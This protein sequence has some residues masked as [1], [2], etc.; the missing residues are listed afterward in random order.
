MTT[1]PKWLRRLV[2]NQ[3]RPGDTVDAVRQAQ[4]WRRWLTA[5]AYRSK[6]REI[7]RLSALPRY[8]PATTTLLGPEMELADAAS[9]LGMYRE[10]FVQESYAFPADTPRPFIIDGGA[11][12]GVSLL[13]FK[14]RY[15]GCEVVAFEPDPVIFQLLQRNVQRMGHDG[16]ELHEKALWS[17]ATTLPFLREGSDGGRV[18]L[19]ADDR[20]RRFNEHC[21]KA[22]TP[23]PAIQ[24]VRLRDYLNRRVD[25]LKLDLEGAEDQVLLDCADALDR[26]ERVF[27]EY[28]SLVSE[29]QRLH[30]VLRVLV[31]AGFR[32]QVHQVTPTS[33]RPFM[34]TYIRWG[35]DLQLNIFASRSFHESRD[36]VMVSSRY[37][38]QE[39]VPVAA[40]GPAA[41]G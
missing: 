21:F 35:M 29:P 41:R 15:P 5:R 14:T 12:V 16:V 18:A 3:E 4:H 9:F 32:V 25:L 1:A 10:I 28:H 2:Y 8:Q 26:V 39:P 30:D 19:V 36:H 40:E 22:W 23:P 6:Y 17:S 31:E 33:P 20:E 24:T 37:R 38:R 34:S 7:A 27:V 13:Y 11:N